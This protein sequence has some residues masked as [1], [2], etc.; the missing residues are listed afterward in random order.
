MKTIKVV[1]LCFESY[2]LIGLGLTGGWMTACAGLI[3]V[4]TAAVVMVVAL[5]ASYVHEEVRCKGFF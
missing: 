5:A 2:Y 3:M 1:I 4:Q